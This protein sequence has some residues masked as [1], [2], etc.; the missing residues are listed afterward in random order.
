MTD[1]ITRFFDAWGAPEPERRAALADAMADEFA[2][3]DPRSGGDL[4]TLDA[5]DAYVARFGAQAPGWSATVTDRHGNARDVE[6][7]VDFS[8]PDGQ[9]G[10]MTQRGRYAVTL[11]TSGRIAR[12][13]G[14]AEGQA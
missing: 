2:Y 1:P 8:G 7:Q 9:G 4:T 14:T 3:A 13:T 11:D 10:T 12:M 6:A 5:L